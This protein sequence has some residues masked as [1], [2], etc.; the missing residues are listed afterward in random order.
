MSECNTSGRLEQKTILASKFSTILQRKIK[1]TI[2]VLAFSSI[3]C[4]RSH[5]LLAVDSS[6]T[7]HGHVLLA[8]DSILSFTALF[9]WLLF[10]V[11]HIIAMF[12]LVPSV[13]RSILV[14]NLF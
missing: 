1:Y 4:H 7:L 3:L 8:V 13:F 14:I 5:A 10:I 12:Y 9:Y 6:S 11:Q 2:I